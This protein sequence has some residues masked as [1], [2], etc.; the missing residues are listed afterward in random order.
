DAQVGDIIIQPGRADGPRDEDNKIG[1]LERFVP[2]QAS[3]NRVDCAVAWTRQEWVKPTH[4]T[5][6]LDPRPL[7]PA[8]GMT[9]LKNG[10]T[11]GS[12]LG[13][14]SAVGVNISVGYTPFPQGAQFVE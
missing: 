12:T 4:V 5:Y 10:R 9:V 2:I 1:I 11:T 14:I 13:I 3:G 6:T 8:L 7:Q